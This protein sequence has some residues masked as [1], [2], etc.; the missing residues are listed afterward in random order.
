ML[1]KGPAERVKPPFGIHMRVIS[2]TRERAFVWWRKF[3]GFLFIEGSIFFFYLVAW[4]CLVESGY[5]IM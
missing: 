1:W 2:F 5:L 3:V 4:D